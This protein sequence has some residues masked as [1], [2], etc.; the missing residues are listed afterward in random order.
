M[1][2]RAPFSAVDVIAFSRLSRGPGNGSHDNH[3][4]YIYVCVCVCVLYG[5][6]AVL[7]ERVMTVSVYFGSVALTN[8]ARV[9]SVN[10]DAYEID[11]FWFF[12]CFGRRDSNTRSSAQDRAVAGV[13]STEP[14]RR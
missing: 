13:L 10:N 14:V 12:V 9:R 5:T 4:N 8:R 1:Y 6:A 11:R 2:A 7:F 3:Y